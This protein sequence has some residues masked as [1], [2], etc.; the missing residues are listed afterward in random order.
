MDPVPGA[1]FY[2]RRVSAIEILI[3]I[4]VIVAV[5]SRRLAGEPLT[6]KRLVGLPAILG[7]VG[8]AGLAKTTHPGAA[9]VGL[10][11]AGLIVGLGF[12]L[13]RGSSV[14][15]GVQNGFLWYRYRWATVAWWVAAI[16]VRIGLMGV[17]RAAHAGHLLSSSLMLGLAVTFLGEAAVVYPRARALDALFAPDRRAA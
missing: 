5:V 12:G 2:G 1:D 4:V 3:V 9:D 10:L 6:M 13:L 16:V 17:E 11:A 8:A 15:V 7:A 14:E